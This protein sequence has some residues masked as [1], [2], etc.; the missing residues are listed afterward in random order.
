MHAQSAEPKAT[1]PTRK[2]AGTVGSRV[3]PLKQPY[4]GT[5]TGTRHFFG[6]LKPKHF[7]IKP[8]HF[9]NRAGLSRFLDRFDML[10]RAR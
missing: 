10:V 8:K 3:Q 9:S 7:S 4:T 5:N 6:T 2:T 1:Q